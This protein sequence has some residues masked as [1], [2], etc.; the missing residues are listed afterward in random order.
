MVRS[1]RNR[2]TASGWRGIAADLVEPVAG[3]ARDHDPGAPLRALSPHETAERPP[4]PSAASGDRIALAR[5]EATWPAETRGSLIRTCG[6][7]LMICQSGP[8]HC[9]DLLDRTRRVP[10]FLA[11]SGRFHR[12]CCRCRL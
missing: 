6:P 9:Q 7:H 11:T 8:L 3:A 4:S 5:A 10:W 1:P 12:T 2:V